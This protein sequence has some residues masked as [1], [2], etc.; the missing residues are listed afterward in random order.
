MLV[1]G[2][3]F[4]LAPLLGGRAPS[5]RAADACFYALLAGSLAFYGIGD[6]PRIPRGSLVVGRG[7][8]PE[9][10]E[11][12][13]AIHPFLLMGAGIAMLAGFW[14]LLGLV[15]RAY[16]SAR[17]PARGFVLAGCAALAVG[18]LQGPIQAFPGGARPA[19]PRRR[20]RRGDREPSRAAEHARRAARDADRAHARAPGTARWCAC[21]VGRARSPSPASA[22]ESRPTTASASRP[23]SPRRTMSHAA[24]PST[25]PSR[26]S[27][28]GPLSC[29]FRRH[30]RFCR[31]S[32]PFAVSVW[33]M[34]ARQRRA[35]ARRSSRRP[36]YSP[37]GS[38][39][40]FGTEP[41]GARRLR[42]ADGPAR[43]PRHRLALCRLPVHRLHAAARRARARRG[44]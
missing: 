34:T 17:A 29:S 14:L 44:R 38:R 40:A 28:R 32:A 5:R 21:G 36:W 27:S 25:T 4:Y 35:G 11:E 39:G 18:T 23:P 20:C 42:A 9:Q 37:D 43:L 30:S 24:R 15:A 13:T 26:G 1:A 22:S 3:L 19:R 6:V 12:A 41:R 16:R 2:A 8:S 31:S 10:A 33:R 7:L